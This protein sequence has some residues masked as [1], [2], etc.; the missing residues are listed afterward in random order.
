MESSASAN[1]KAKRPAT[2]WLAII[3]GVLLVFSIFA[4][5]ILFAALAVISGKEVKEGEL[6]RYEEHF[7][8]GDK[9]SSNKILRIPVEGPIIEGDSGLVADVINSFKKASGDSDIKAIIME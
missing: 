3:F 4:N 1:P 7:V 6:A 8:T 2:F 5:F 9:A